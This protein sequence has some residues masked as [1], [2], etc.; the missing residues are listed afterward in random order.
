MLLNTF[1][2]WM[3]LHLS[4]LISYSYHLCM[5]PLGYASQSLSW[6]QLDMGWYGFVWKLGIR[7]SS[8]DELLAPEFI[9]MFTSISLIRACKYIYIFNEKKC[10]KLP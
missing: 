1:D 2:G 4:S 9:M 6:I 7:K 8:S 5:V 10:C 3:T